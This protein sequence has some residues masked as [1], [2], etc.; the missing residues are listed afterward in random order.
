MDRIT[1]PEAGVEEGEGREEA[2]EDR[3]EPVS[4]PTAE[5]KYLMTG[6]YHAFPFNARSAAQ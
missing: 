3:Q 4:A 6:E 5:Q 2:A 1:T